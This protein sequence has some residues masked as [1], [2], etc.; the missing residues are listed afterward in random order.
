LGIQLALW[1]ASY[2]SFGFW[3]HAASDVLTAVLILIIPLV[4]LV[5]RLFASYRSD[6]PPAP[7]A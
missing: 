4:P 5:G 1:G 6:S 3:R 2:I 7:S